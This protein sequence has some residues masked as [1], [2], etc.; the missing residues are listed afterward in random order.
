MLSPRFIPRF[1]WMLIACLMLLSCQIQ[2]EESETELAAPR[3]SC[4][5]GS[6]SFNAKCY[7]LFIT[8]KSWMEATIACQRWRS[9]HLTSVLS[10]LEAS[11]L[12]SML[13][14]EGNENAYVWI[15]LH[16]PTERGN[17][18][19]WSNEDV[20]NYFAW[21][22]IPPSYPNP[23]HCGALLKDSDYKE[24]KDLSCDVELPYV[25]MF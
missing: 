23:G 3:I 12:S 10:K 17:G 2:G 25:C 19:K 15:G 1:F 5:Q 11:F 9:S 7:A 13:I 8:P 24:W 4:P 6:S 20:M 16:D 18:W 14:G 22:K 21:R